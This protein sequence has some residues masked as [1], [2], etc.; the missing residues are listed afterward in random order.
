MLALRNSCRTRA[1]RVELTDDFYL[2]PI[3]FYGGGGVQVS[4]CDNLSARQLY[5]WMIRL[6]LNFYLLLAIRRPWT[7]AANVM[8]VFF[9]GREETRYAKWFRDIFK[10]RRRWRQTATKRAPAQ[11]ILPAASA[12][13]HEE[14]CSET[15][16][17][18]LSIEGV[19]EPRASACAEQR[20]AQVSTS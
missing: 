1:R 10:T 9:S 2:S 19:E 7:V 5:G 16:F 20:G 8:R 6:Y 14:C 17:V 4:Y 11:Q 12:T 3:D 18:Q 15:E 13:V